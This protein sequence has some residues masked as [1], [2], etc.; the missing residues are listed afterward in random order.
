MI[1][2][3]HSTGQQRHEGDKSAKSQAH[4]SPFQIKMPRRSTKPHFLVERKFEH[5]RNI[6]IIMSPQCL[7]EKPW[8]K[9]PIQEEFSY[10]PLYWEWLEDVLTRCRGLLVANHLFEALYASLFYWCPETNFLHTLKGEISISL[11]DIHSFLGLPLSGFLY[12]E[13]L[14]PSNQ[15]KTSLARSCAHLFSAYHILRQCFDQ[16]EN[17]AISHGIFFMLG[18]PKSSGFGQAKTFELDGA[19]ELIRFGGGFARILLSGT[20]S[21]RLSLVMTNYHGLA[22]LILLVFIRVTFVAI[23]K[24]VLLWSTITPTSSGSKP[25]LKIILSQKI[26]EP[27][28]L[29]TK[30]NTPQRKIPRIGAAISS[31]AMTAKA[32]DEARLTLKPSPTTAYR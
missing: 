9:L 19:R 28:V 21:K 2:F 8:E 26:L 32:S 23:A 1:V 30:D 14:P 24:I 27:H 13:V 17:E 4:S 31:I 10:T 3:V 16:E 12:D 11:L 22:L 29:E 6:F 15:H 7:R 25:K 5:K 18:I 20:E